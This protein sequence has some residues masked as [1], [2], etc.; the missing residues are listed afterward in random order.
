MKKTL[1]VLL[2]L[3]LT[4]A[5]SVAAGAVLM[6]WEEADQTYWSPDFSLNIDKGDTSE[7]LVILEDGTI[8]AGNGTGS[9]YEMENLE[10]D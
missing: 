4:V 6:T 7:Y 9:W 10:G 1:S 8:S 3:L 2:A 5:L